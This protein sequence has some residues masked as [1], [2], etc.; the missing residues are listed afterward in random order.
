MPTT[1]ETCGAG[2]V[3]AFSGS[4]AMSATFSSTAYIGFN[5]GQ[6]ANGTNG[7]VVPAGTGLTV[8]YTN[9]GGS[10]L[11]VQMQGPT[12]DTVATDRWC[13]DLVAAAGPV[14]IPYTSFNTECWAPVTTGA[15]AKQPIKAVQ[16]VIPGSDMA[17]V[18]FDVTLVSVTE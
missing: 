16:L 17:A 10:P 12:G 7:T 2:C 15:Y 8:N 3:L 14:T 9:A 1:F 6:A 4:V 11:R 13:A 5:I 18:P